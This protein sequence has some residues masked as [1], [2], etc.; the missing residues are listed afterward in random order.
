VQLH[1]T[2]QS[3]VSVRIDL[4]PNPFLSSSFDS[5]CQVLDKGRRRLHRLRVQVVPSLFLSSKQDPVRR[6]I[7]SVADR[8][9]QDK[10]KDLLAIGVRMTGCL[11]KGECHE[12][13]LDRP[14]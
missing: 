6:G 5:L 12:G 2:V 11:I 1:G 13:Q 8:A 4:P 3:S 10:V 9:G 7:G 14:C